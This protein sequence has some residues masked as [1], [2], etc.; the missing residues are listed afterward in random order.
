MNQM[1]SFFQAM[2]WQGFLLFLLSVVAV[3]LCLTIHE[4]SHG[5]AAY[6]LGD[7][8]AKS[9]NR[10]SL[11]PLHHLDF[12]GTMMMLVAG[13]GWAKPVPVD[14][15][16]F[17]HPKSGMAITALAGP[18][19]NFLLAYV[20]ILIRAILL[21]LFLSKGWGGWEKIDFFLTTL[22]SMSIG[23]GIFNLIPFPPLDGS[24]VL[25]GIL[26]DRIYYTILRY[27]RYGIFILVAILWTGILDE[28]LYVVRRWILQSLVSGS[29]WA[30]ELVMRLM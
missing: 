23:L 2:D 21:P 26:P 29:L 24:K 15:R 30:A 7:P 5:L 3:L 19:S 9:Q 28:P 6:L 25:E 17:K 14:L 12:F 27:E 20:A 13:F 10:L 1:N 8:T 18:M 11:N 4:L 16:Y 22:A